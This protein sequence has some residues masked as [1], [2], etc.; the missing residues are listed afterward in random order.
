MEKGEGKILHFNLTSEQRAQ[1]GL[2][3]WSNIDIF[4][5]PIME[6]SLNIYREVLKAGQHGE[7]GS[8]ATVISVDGVFPKMEGVKEF[9][10]AS[11]EKTGS[12]FL[13]KDLEERILGEAE[14]VLRGRKIEIL[15]ISSEEANHPWKTLEVL[16]EPII[17]EPTVYIFGAGH[18]SPQ[19]VPLVKKV[20]FKAVVIDDREI[21][22]NRELFPE[23]DEVI[24]IEFEK[25]FEQLTIDQSSYIVIVTRGHL[26]DGLIL[27]NAVKTD[28]HYIGMIGSKKKIQTLYQI[29]LKEG[30]PEGLLKRVHAPIGLDIGSEPPEEIA[31]SI[32]AE[33]IKV[34][35]QGE[36]GWG[37]YRL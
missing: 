35:G 27:G 5:E 15:A 20:N 2:S 19:L 9:I 16:L 21:F 37:I 1:G 10:K 18:I 26:Y 22:A 25:A 36:G 7:T 13:G 6:D 11:G 8:L 17:S 32:V 23:A 29:L 34:R 31:V 24:V 12:L 14:R 4:L 33:L 28:A 3:C 30:I